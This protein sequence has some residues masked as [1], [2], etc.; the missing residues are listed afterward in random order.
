MIQQSKLNLGQFCTCNFA[1]SLKPILMLQIFWPFL[2]IQF[3]APSPLPPPSNGLQ[4]I[5]MYDTTKHPHVGFIKI[6]CPRQCQKGPRLRKTLKYE[7]PRSSDS[8]VSTC[9][10]PPLTPSHRS[11][12]YLKELY[13]SIS[14]LA[15]KIVL[16]LLNNEFISKILNYRG[17]H[18]G[19]PP[20]HQGF[21][22][23]IIFLTIL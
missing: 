15:Q 6:L 12:I 20:P 14:T 23:F 17:G 3:L 1:P 10:L 7:K 8:D 4:R 2:G 11:L 19:P 22:K 18:I 9:M 13:T 21:R 5:Y 16:T